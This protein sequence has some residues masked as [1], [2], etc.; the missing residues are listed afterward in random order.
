MDSPHHQFDQLLTSEEYEQVLDI[1]RGYTST[2]ESSYTHNLG[3]LNIEGLSLPTEPLDRITAL[4]NSLLEPE[5]PLE[6]IMTPLCVIYSAEYGEP[7]LPT[8]FDGD[9]TDFIIDYQL[10]ANTAWPL[11]ADLSVYPLKNNQA[12]GFNPN[13][14]IHWRPEK[15]FQPGEYVVMIFFR[16]FNP[17]NPSDYS[18]LPHHP[19]DPIFKEAS[20]YRDSF[21]L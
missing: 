15:K 9:S 8:H 2:A 11:G 7:H 6:M 10:T 13:K 4:V 16:F 12:V 17:R 14:T 21:N 1:V 20:E 5:E 18:H 19:E 3:R